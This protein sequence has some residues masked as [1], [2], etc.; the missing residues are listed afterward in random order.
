MVVTI[1]H[2]STPPATP[3]ATAMIS[4]VLSV[5]SVSI[6]YKN[7]VLLEFGIILDLRGYLTSLKFIWL[8]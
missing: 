1:I 7:K 2:R 4:S 6:E 3:Q 5:D 8:I